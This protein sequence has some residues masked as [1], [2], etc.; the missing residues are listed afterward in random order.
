[1]ELKVLELVPCVWLVSVPH[2]VWHWWCQMALFLVVVVVV[3]SRLLWGACRSAD[4]VMVVL[5]WIVLCPGGRGFV[6]VLVL[7]TLVC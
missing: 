5:L 4:V 2:L 7:V 6:I 3:A 1:M